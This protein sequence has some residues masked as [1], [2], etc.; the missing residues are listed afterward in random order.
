MLLNGDAGEINKDQKDFLKEIYKGNQRMVDL[1][2]ALLNVSR[3]EMGTLAIEPESI[4][5]NKIAESVLKEIKPQIEKKKQKLS[6]KLDKQVP[7]IQADPK[8]IRIIFQNLISNAVKYTPNEGKIFVETEKEEKNILIKVS[9][10]G[11]GIPKDQHDKIFSKL[12]RAD[13]VQEKDAEGTGLGLY[14]I[15]SIVEQCG[16]QIWFES[17]KNQGTTFFVRF[18]LQGMSEQEGSRGLNEIK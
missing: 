3:I 15:R 18:P 8:L 4:D 1:V 14:I 12:F 11:Y 10:N 13:N 2:N 5:F 16:G 6:K 9:D 17:E 7:K